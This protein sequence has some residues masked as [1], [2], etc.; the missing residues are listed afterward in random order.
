[1]NRRGE[2]NIRQHAE[3]RFYSDLADFRW[4]QDVRSIE[5]TNYER[6]EDDNE[7]LMRYLSD[8]GTTEHEIEED[9]I[10]QGR[11][12]FPP[13]SVGD[14]ELVV[15][16]DL[17]EKTHSKKMGDREVFEFIEN[18]RTYFCDRETFELLEGSERYNRR[19]NQQVRNDYIAG[20]ALYDRIRTAA[21]AVVAPIAL[22]NV[23]LIKSKETDEETGQSSEIIML[24]RQFVYTDVGVPLYVYMEANPRISAALAEKIYC[25]I[26]TAIEKL[27]LAGFV[28]RNLDDTSVFVKVG[29]AP[30]QDV[31]V[32]L[33]NFRNA[34]ETTD[35]GT[36]NEDSGRLRNFIWEGAL[37]Q[38]GPVPNPTKC[39]HAVAFSRREHALHA[40]HAAATA[41]GTGAGATRRGRLSKKRRSTRRK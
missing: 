9:V 11:E 8:S 36:R 1:M 38:A 18:E 16:Y 5:Y 17:A 15:L 6:F 32:R 24:E 28:H 37:A 26:Y 29:P 27:H 20:I 2:F 4:I 13:H 33:F 21:P 3:D 14:A 39:R 41:A 35:P 10:R 22:A 34:V 19:M 30:R 25:G 40:V 23:G 7:R 31:E 12:V